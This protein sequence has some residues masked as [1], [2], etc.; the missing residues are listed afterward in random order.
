L[1]E[2]PK[3]PIGEEPRPI[4]NI[5]TFPEVIARFFIIWVIPATGRASGVLQDEGEVDPK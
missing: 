1:D 4:G 3:S 5:G 2:R